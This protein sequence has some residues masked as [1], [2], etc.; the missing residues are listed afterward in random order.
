MKE[1]FRG[2]VDED[3]VGYQV[4]CAICLCVKYA[5]PCIDVAYAATRGRCDRTTARSGQQQTRCGRSREGEEEERRREE[6]RE[7][8]ETRRE[9]ERGRRE[10]GRRERAWDA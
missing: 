2:N 7:R 1:E 9:E 6:G 3:P 8:R 4:S 10:R 5:L